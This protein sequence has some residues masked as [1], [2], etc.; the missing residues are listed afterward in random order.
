[1][2]DSDGRPN[3]DFAR[4][5]H[6]SSYSTGSGTKY[7]EYAAGHYLT[8]KLEKRARI[9]GIAVQGSPDSLRYYLKSMELWYKVTIND[10]DVAKSPTTFETFYKE[11]N[12][13]KVITIHFG[14]VYLISDSIALISLL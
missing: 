11:A 8:I 13:T 2:T 12:K 6:P 14:F 4:L 9:Y 10:L 1:M 5:D 7:H 3:A